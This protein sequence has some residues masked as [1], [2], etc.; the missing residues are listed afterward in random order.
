MDT[1]NLVQNEAAFAD[2]GELSTLVRSFVSDCVIV[3]VVDKEIY[4]CIVQKK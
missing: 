1:C 4:F 2:L 3:L